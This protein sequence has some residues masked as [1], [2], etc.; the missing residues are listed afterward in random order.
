MAAQ[1]FSSPLLVFMDSEIFISG[2]SK[3]KCLL[4]ICALFGKH[5]S[6]F[7]SRF[8]A[9]GELNMS[10]FDAWV[11]STLSLYWFA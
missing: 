7:F 9:F 1:I 6:Q 4:S 11:S 8:R 2:C 3:I 5:S 10:P